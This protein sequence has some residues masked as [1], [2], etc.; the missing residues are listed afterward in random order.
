MT[1]DATAG[2]VLVRVGGRVIADTRTALTL[3]E[4]SYAPTQFEAL[5]II[6]AT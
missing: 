5:E 1:I 4:A 6:Q 2:R 3:R